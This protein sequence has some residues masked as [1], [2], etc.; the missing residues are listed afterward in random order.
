MVESFVASNFIDDTVEIKFE[1][2]TELK[3]YL[4]QM[5]INQKDVTADTIV[6]AMDE[7]V[8]G[9]EK[10]GVVVTMWIILQKQI[11]MYLNTKRNSTVI[12]EVLGV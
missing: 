10:I 8:N 3:G 4:H 12:A 5:K 9:L 1:T 2:G 11:Y 6:Y 7:M